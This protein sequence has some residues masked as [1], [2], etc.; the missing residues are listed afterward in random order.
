MFHG[1]GCLPWEYKIQLNKDVQPV[2]HPP[3]RVPVPK[4]EAMKTE[5]DQM[6]ADKIVT[7]EPTDWVS[8]VLQFLRRMDQS[9]FV[10]IQEVWTLPLSALTTPYRQ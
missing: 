8:S 1:I 2:V 7:T 10:W 9:V 5:L 6:V 4:K 3:R